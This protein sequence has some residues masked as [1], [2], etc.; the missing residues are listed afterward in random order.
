M[1]QPFKR[2]TPALREGEK[3]DALGRPY[4]RW[5]VGYKPKKRLDVRVTLSRQVYAKAKLVAA[6]RGHKS[7]AAYLR[8]LLQEDLDAAP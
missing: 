2:P 4:R 7:I 3:Q 6:Y 1:T 5:P 8:S